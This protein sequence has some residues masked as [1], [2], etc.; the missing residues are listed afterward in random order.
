MFIN[1]D[2]RMFVYNV[3]VLF[4]KV[5]Q[6]IHQ[7]ASFLCLLW[8]PNNEYWDHDVSRVYRLAEFSWLPN[9]GVLNPD[10]CPPKA[11]Q[12]HVAGRKDSQC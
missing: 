5:L 9:T 12:T 11:F 7:S 4:L 8:Q 1:I 3:H 10:V 2:A 6:Q